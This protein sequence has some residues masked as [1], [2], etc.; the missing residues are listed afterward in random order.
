MWINRASASA[1]KSYQF[2]PFQYWLNHVLGLDSPSGKAALQGNIV[3]QVLEWMGQLVAKGKTIDPHW[4]LDW[5]WDMHVAANPQ[6]EIRRETRRGESADFRFCRESLDKVLRHPIYD[7]R[8]LKVIGTEVRLDLSLP[9]EL[10][11]LRDGK[12]FR[13]TG[14]MDL[15]HE[16]SADTIEVVDWKTGRRQDFNTQR[17]KDFYD[18][19]RDVQPRLYHLA[20]TQMYPQYPNVLVTF[21][22]INDGGPIS[23]PF[24]A[25]DL[26]PTLGS[27]WRFFDTVR[28]DQ[29]INRSRTWRCTRFCHYGRTGLCDRIWADLHAYGQEY[30]ELKYTPR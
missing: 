6:V 15:V 7:P 11:Q 17:E 2:C 13:V 1:V 12:Q 19:M 25:D 9:G 29:Q 16:A 10:W 5:A 22:Y 14:Y 23:L 8:R 4:L 30:V 3:H 20:A 21:Y 27:V 28:R 18:L 24:T 26:A